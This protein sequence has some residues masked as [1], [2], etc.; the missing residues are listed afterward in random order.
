MACK[1]LALLVAVLLALRCLEG[2]SAE[3][4][5][6]EGGSVLL[7]C[8]IPSSTGTPPS[9]VSAVKQLS[10]TKSNKL[11]FERHG[12]FPAS[13]GSGYFHR[14][15]VQ[16]PSS[17]M[18]R[19]N[20]THLR[21]RDNGLYSCRVELENG[22]NSVQ[23]F[24]LQLWLLPK[25]EANESAVLTRTLHRQAGEYVVL[26]CPKFRGRP[27][28]SVSWLVNER[29]LANR[30]RVRI[31]RH[32]P[33]QLQ[34]YNLNV[35]DSGRYAC[36]IKNPYGVSEF[37]FTVLVGAGAAF[38]HRPPPSQTTAVEGARLELPCDFHADPGLRARVNWQRAQPGSK[39]KL[40][41]SLR[42]SPDASV[43]VGHQN[44]SLIFPALDH[45]H[46]GTYRCQVMVGSE[47]HL[48]SRPS[49]VTVLHPPTLLPNSSRDQF[50]PLG[51]PGSLTCPVFANPPV[52]TTDWIRNSSPI[53]AAYLG[54][55]Y[56]F[57]LVTPSHSGRY[58]CRALQTASSFNTWSSWTP[59]FTVQTVQSPR[60]IAR[61]LALYQLA[62]GESVRMP[63]A[64]WAPS[65]VP[66]G[67]VWLRNGRRLD[68]RD[69]RLAYDPLDQELS[70][71][72]VQP[73]LEGTYT[74][75][76]ENPVLPLA[77][78]ARLLVELTSP[79]PPANLTVVS[80]TPFSLHLTWQPAYD[81]GRALHYTV[82]YRRLGD[83]TWN[84][85]LAD[86]PTATEAT[87]TKL[88]ADTAYELSLTSKSVGSSAL[89]MRVRPETTAG[90]T[91]GYSPELADRPLP[92]DRSGR[93]W[94]PPIQRS[95][96]PRP[97]P[98]VPASFDVVSAGVL[99]IAW[100]PPMS[101]LVPVLY[102][103]LEVGVWDSS[104]D[105]GDSWEEFAQVLQPRAS[106]SIDAQ[107]LLRVQAAQAAATQRR[108]RIAATSCALLSR[109]RRVVVADVD[110]SQL[111]EL[112]PA[113]SA[114]AALAS[115]GVNRVPAGAA[116]ALLS[117]LLSFLVLAGALLGLTR[118]SARRSPRRIV[119]VNKNDDSS[120]Q[121]RGML[122]KQHTAADFL[123]A[124]PRERQPQLRRH[125]CRTR[126]CCC[127][128]QQLAA[129][130]ASSEHPL[131]LA[132]RRGQVDRPVSEPESGFQSDGRGGG[133][134]SDDDCPPEA[135]DDEV[136]VSD[137]E[138]TL[139]PGSWQV[140]GWSRRLPISVY[141][142]SYHRIK[143]LRR[144]SFPIYRESELL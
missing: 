130:G 42:S 21:E 18:H 7:D 142:D 4:R 77:A 86:P 73:D 36:R 62:L 34:V 15:T 32:L 13:L 2:D 135:N 43:A 55:R 23:E 65:N 8:R 107:P 81:A 121:R 74:C 54:R 72:D 97:G 84:S 12:N 98:P 91:A 100:Q 38:I 80:V 123:A 106:L 60:F 122:N 30:G 53:G 49:A 25:F 108:F 93:P 96:G 33:E 90:R 94:F 20:L 58:R 119:V 124:E 114:A 141:L 131:L 101:T 47:L 41:T 76:L 78:S 116:W 17:Q 63:C 144:A 129:T 125:R 48:I 132:S 128:Q 66:T 64:F 71:R 27:Q 1:L 6:V 52:D 117:C 82:W 31:D 46:S 26:R 118:S 10:L 139:P 138:S 89:E 112:L 109:S 11:A 40:W 111:S 57:N 143:R 105:K 44:S 45:S 24:H 115:T 75:A 140:H 39:L 22:D 137:I 68:Y 104:L 3:L 5:A 51:Q 113:G 95:L 126:R 136:S 14:L 19:F 28:P 92:R 59:E 120:Q 69:R 110:P 127:R 67:L 50:L 87:V 83:K 9:D 35:N 85:Q 134:H 56:R 61:P 133:S 29:P 16:S 79:H 99:C 102:Y 37:D 70:V 88:L 103:R